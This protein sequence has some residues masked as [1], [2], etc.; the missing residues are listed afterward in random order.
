MKRKNRKRKNISGSNPC[1]ICK[2]VDY[3]EEHHIQGRKVKN[4]HADNNI[5]CLCPSC[6]T[7]IH[8]GDIIIEKWALT[9]LGRELLWHHKD[10]E[11]FTGEK[12]NV[13]L[14]KR[15]N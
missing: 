11:S 1:D 15:S 7:K 10:G 9:S 12:S 8:M 5:A 4:P 6:H 3:L 2:K 14:I 13:H